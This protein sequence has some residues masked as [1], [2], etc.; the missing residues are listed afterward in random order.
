M[1]P[2]TR[3]TLEEVAAHR[4]TASVLGAARDRV[5]RTYRPVLHRD[6]GRGVVTLPDDPAFR[7][8]LDLGPV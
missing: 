3:H 1:L 5:V 2:P 6:G 4:D 8:E 7:A